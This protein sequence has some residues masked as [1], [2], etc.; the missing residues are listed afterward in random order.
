MIFL[1]LLLLWVRQ[2][3][4]FAPLIRW[5][6]G[7]IL[8]C[9][10]FLAIPGGTTPAAGMPADDVLR[11]NGKY[12]EGTRVNGLVGSFDEAGARWTFTSSDSAVALRVLENQSLQRIAKAI[13]EDHNDKK[14]KISGVLTEF[15]DEN[16]LLIDRVQRWT[17]GEDA[18]ETR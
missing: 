15:Q 12:R 17:E 9:G 7:A 2:P 6:F 18:A 16:F 10:L 5:S 14:W 13:A 8:A 4:Q 11:A 1:P 3:M